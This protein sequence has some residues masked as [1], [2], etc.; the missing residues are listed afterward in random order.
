LRDAAESVTI[1]RD[2]SDAGGR[3]GT[4]EPPPPSPPPA[5][6]PPRPAGR[7][8]EC[9]GK[10]A[11][12]RGGAAVPPPPRR[13]A[14][15]GEGAPPSSC[16]SVERTSGPRLPRGR[17]DANPFLLFPS[18]GTPPT[19]PMSFAEYVKKGGG[20]VRVQGGERVPSMGRD[21][22]PAPSERAGEVT[23]SQGPNVTARI[24]GISNKVSPRGAPRRGVSAGRNH[25]VRQI[26]RANPRSR[27]AAPPPPRGSRPCR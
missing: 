21:Q 26:R 17:A 9:F 5:P 15:A 22:A 16:P 27:H 4:E 20:T 8:G 11:R 14:G 13:A 7:A 2:L 23:T 24:F 10:T 6:P 19:T 3:G 18:L 1:Q 12:P 25:C